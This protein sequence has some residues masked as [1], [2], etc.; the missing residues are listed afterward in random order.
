LTQ[1]TKSWQLFGEYRPCSIVIGSL[2]V[3]AAKL[4][5]THANSADPGRVAK[6]VKERDNLY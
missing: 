4:M 1:V 6:A 3:Y 2:W 5:R